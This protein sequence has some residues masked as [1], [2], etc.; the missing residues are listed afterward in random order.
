M[1]P[2]NS[3]E[4]TVF[5]QIWGE[6]S[7]F[8][9]RVSFLTNKKVVYVFMKTSNTEI[10]FS[11]A[12]NWDDLD[13]IRVIAALSFLSVDWTALTQRYHCDEGQLVDSFCPNRVTDW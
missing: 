12:K 8:K 1:D 11:H 6:L 7:F 5:W 2:P 3:Q 10:T 4:L 9:G 13:L